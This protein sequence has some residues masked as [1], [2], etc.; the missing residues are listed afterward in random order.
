[1]AEKFQYE[2]THRGAIAMA[3][4]MWS[5]WNA[6]AAEAWKSWREAQEAWV[7]STD[8]SMSVILQKNAEAFESQYWRAVKERDWWFKTIVKHDGIPY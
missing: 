7:E 2:T 3:D 6:I 8:D 4:Y 5:E 1:M